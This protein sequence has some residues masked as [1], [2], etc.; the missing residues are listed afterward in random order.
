MIHLQL[1]LVTF[2]KE[3]HKHLFWY[4]H[5]TCGFLEIAVRQM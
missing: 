4:A 1:W 2:T 5:K 3:M